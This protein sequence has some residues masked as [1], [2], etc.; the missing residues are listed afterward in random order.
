MVSLWNTITQ[1]TQKDKTTPS[2]TCTN[3]NR[4]GIPPATCTPK[5]QWQCITV[6]T[7][8]VRHSRLP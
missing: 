4:T 2:C 3:P 7:G 5:F 1:N 8:T 6:A